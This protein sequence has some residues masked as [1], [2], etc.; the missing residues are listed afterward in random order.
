M[1]PFFWGEGAGLGGRG[2]LNGFKRRPKGA[3]KGGKTSTGKPYDPSWQMI[4][5]RRECPGRNGEKKVG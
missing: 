1:G 5:T 2:G 3:Q 4:A